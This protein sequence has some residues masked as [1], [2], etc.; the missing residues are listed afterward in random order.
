MVEIGG[1]YKAKDLV[2]HVLKVQDKSAICEI[3]YLNGKQHNCAGYTEF[4]VDI[5]SLIR[6]A[7]VKPSK[8]DV[9]PSGYDINGNLIRMPLFNKDHEK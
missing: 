4:N 6:M 3:Y 9:L 1:Y 7:R 5:Y 2:Y 8:K